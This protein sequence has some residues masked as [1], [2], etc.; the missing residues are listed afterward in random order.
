MNKTVIVSILFY[1][2]FFCLYTL[3]PHIFLIRRAQAIN[4]TNTASHYIH[5][6]VSRGKPSDD[7]DLNV[8]PNVSRLYFS[9]L[10][11]ICSVNLFVANAPPWPD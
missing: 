3:L 11:F 2:I 9:F 4:F 6:F 5:S 1:H 8:A 7:D 10:H